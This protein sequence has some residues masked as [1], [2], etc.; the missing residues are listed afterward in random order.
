MKN[1]SIYVGLVIMILF[2]V[3]SFILKDV[4]ICGL[5]IAFS[6]IIGAVLFRKLSNQ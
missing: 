6:I 2:L 5:V 1:I 4:I 3:I